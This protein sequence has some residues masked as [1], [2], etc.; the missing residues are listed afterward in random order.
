MS[1]PLQELYSITIHAD[2]FSTTCNKFH[3]YP[4][5]SLMFCSRKWLLSQVRSKYMTENPIFT[6]NLMSFGPEY[7]KNNC[8]LVLKDPLCVLFVWDRLITDF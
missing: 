4:F 7:G 6:H 2:N 3:C 8:F 1:G 5:M